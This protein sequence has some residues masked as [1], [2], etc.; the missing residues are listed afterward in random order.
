[1]KVQCDKPKVN[2]NIVYCS[3]SVV[4]CAVVST[5]QFDLGNGS[6]VDVPDE[7]FITFKRNTLRIVL[8]IDPNQNVVLR[9][10]ENIARL[11]FWTG[12]NGTRVFVTTALV[13]LE[14]IFGGGIC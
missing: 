7:L 4:H 3:R 8:R 5:L 1:M 11:F 9:R 12:F 10:F 13:P 14:E 2:Q 6:R